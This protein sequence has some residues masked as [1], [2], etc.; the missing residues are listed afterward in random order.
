[1]KKFIDVEATAKKIYNKYGTHPVY[2]SDDRTKE[3]KDAQTDC[4]VL[5]MIY[6]KK[7]MVYA[8][9]VEVVRCKD[10]RFAEWIGPGLFICHND[11]IMT[12]DGYVT[13]MWYCA[14]GE[15]VKT[16]AEG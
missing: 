5:E 10:C 16:D 1:M 13:A 14:D 11:D 6:D 2:Y 12:Y 15:K 3:G 9:A 4:I 7:R 8:D